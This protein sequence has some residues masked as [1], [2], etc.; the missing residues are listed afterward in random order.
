MTPF[1]PSRRQLL[2]GVGAL[3]ATAVGA[4]YAAAASRPRPYTRYTYAQSTDGVDLL[5]IAWYETYNGAYR[6]SQ[7]PAGTPPQQR[8]ASNTDQYATFDGASV[9][10]DNALPGDHGSVVLG[11]TPA[12]ETAVRLWFRFALVC[13]PENGVNEPEEHVDTAANGDFDG[14]LADALR[15][16]VWH[17]DGIAGLGACDGSS[18]LAGIAEP[19]IATGTPGNSVAAG[20]YA[21]EDP[22][23]GFELAVV[24]GE[25]GA[26]LEPGAHRCFGFEW[27]IPEA[28]GNRVQTDGLQLVLQFVPVTCEDPTNPFTSGLVSDPSDVACEVSDD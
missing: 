9:S 13:A 23:D 6:S 4:G 20:D 7:L 19:R 22:V 25:I 26:C 14:E 27:A 15:F 16:A 11:V 24:P 17:D 1:A 10:V 2:A 12:S 28:V 3:G 5:R 8:D 21:G 18:T